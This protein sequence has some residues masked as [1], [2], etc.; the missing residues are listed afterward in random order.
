MLNQIL[1]LVT[2]LILLITTSFLFPIDSKN[3][4][5]Y[6]H[7]LMNETVSLSSFIQTYHPLVLEDP[8]A[9]KEFEVVFKARREALLAG[10]KVA[11][12]KLGRNN[13]YEDLK[14]LTFKEGKVYVVEIDNELLM[15][16][17][18][19]DS[20]VVSSIIVKKGNMKYFLML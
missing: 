8:A 19:R 7:D 11:I 13:N 9:L 2:K 1:D 20:K 17:L 4:K 10:N 15:P 18:V 6:V 14:N 12:K 16:L 3:A 5:K